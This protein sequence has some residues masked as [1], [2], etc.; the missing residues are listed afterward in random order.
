[1]PI[2]SSDLPKHMQQQSNQV[3]R[4]KYGVRV[5]E[6]GKRARTHNGIVYDSQAEMKRAAQLDIELAAGVIRGWL[7]Q[8]TVMLGVPENRYTVDFVVVGLDG[9]C[10]AEDVKG[11]ETASFK[12]N[13]KLWARY[14]PMPLH[15]LGRRERYVITPADESSP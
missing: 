12:R 4:N 6:A 11:H 7:R 15:V 3:R 5:D 14:G 13:K 9:V 2:R 1:M 8:T 10:W